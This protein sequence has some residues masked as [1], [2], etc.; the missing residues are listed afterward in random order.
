MKRPFFAATDSILLLGHRRR[1]PKEVHLQ[2]I[3]MKLCGEMIKSTTEFGSKIRL[4][5]SAIGKIQRD[6]FLLVKKS[7]LG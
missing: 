1:T 5:A 4:L 7:N 3:N 2:I 6:M